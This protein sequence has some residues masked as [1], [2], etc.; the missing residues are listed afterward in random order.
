MLVGFGQAIARAS[1]RQAVRAC[2]GAIVSERIKDLARTGLSRDAIAQ[3]LK[4]SRRLVDR[5]LDRGLR[6]RYLLLR[7][8]GTVWELES[9]ELFASEP[10]LRAYV[11]ILDPHL[12]FRAVKI[13][14]PP[15]PDASP[16]P[17]CGKPNDRPRSVCRAC[18]RERMAAVT[19]RVREERKRRG[20]CQTCGHRP[21]LEGFTICGE[22][23]RFKQVI[24]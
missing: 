19:G 1:L 12:H 14:M 7:W 5:A 9:A 8:S 18:H 16:C 10:K 22:C 6:F 20:L 11:S 13:V 23:K 24:A 3:K 2:D 4:V 15:H 21:P 17:A